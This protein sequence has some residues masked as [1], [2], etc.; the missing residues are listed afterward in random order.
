M[1][2]ELEQHRAIEGERDDVGACDA[3]VAGLQRIAQIGFSIG[4]QLP[5]IEQRAGQAL[6][7]F[8]HHPALL[9]A[10]TVGFGYEDQLVGIERDRSG[11]G[12]IFHRQ[13]EGFAGGR[14]TEGGQQ[15]QRIVAQRQPDG[16]GVDL[17]DQSGVFEIDAADDADR[18]G[19]HEVARD[20]ANGRVRHRGVGQALRE[21]G[22]DIKTGLTGGFLGAFEGQCIGDPDTVVI[23]ALRTPQ[24]HLLIDL[25]A[26]AKD[27]HQTHAHRVQ[28][29]QVLRQGVEP[30]V[31]HQLAGKADDQCFAPES[32]DIRRHGTKPGDELRMLGVF[33]HRGIII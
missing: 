6:G 16:L 18:P 17:S 13:V 22:F 15:H 26:G 10:H 31:G 25:R 12:D 33:I 2:K 32:V 1:Q 8:G 24:G 7:D 21:S 30:P 19:G 27:Q 5:G 3:A 14:K 23:A 4:R 9:V 20:D 28:Q 11:G 29:A